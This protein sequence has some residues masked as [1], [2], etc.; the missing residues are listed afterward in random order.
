MLSSK[1]AC[2]MYENTTMVSLRKVR[3]GIFGSFL[4]VGVGGVGITG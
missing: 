2:V 3:V 4:D 1:T